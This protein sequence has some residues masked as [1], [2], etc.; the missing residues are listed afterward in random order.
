MKPTF[1]RAA[2]TSLL[3][4]TATALAFAQ[5]A[6]NAGARPPGAQPAQ[7]A[8]PPVQSAPVPPPPPPQVSPFAGVWRY[9]GGDGERRAFEAAVQR[10]VQGLGWIIEGMAASRIRDSSP[11]PDTITIRVQ[12]NQIEYIGV[13]GRLIRSPADGTTIQTTNAQ[14]EPISLSTRINGNQMVRNGVR[15]EGSRREVLTVNGNTMI[16]EG[17][18][19]APRLPRPLVYRF[20]F[21][22]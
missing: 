12:N 3:V 7:P 16:V 5:T 2:V 10:A 21:R 13:R 22:R 8:Q 4:S 14:G 15:S 17:T 18:V 6:P 20:T 19:S 11:I 1:R 9:A